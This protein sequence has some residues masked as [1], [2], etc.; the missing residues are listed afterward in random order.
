[1]F[2]RLFYQIYYRRH[3]RTPFLFLVFLLAIVFL[4]QQR[5]FSSTSTSTIVDS[6]EISIVKKKE[7][8]SRET[9]VVPENCYRCPGENGIGVSLTVSCSTFAKTLRKK[10]P[11]FMSLG[12]R[13]ARFGS[14]SEKRLF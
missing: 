11:F 14:N 2:H 4:F 13:S 8:I 7:R 3:R 9:Y 1:M 6:T 5:P 10:K 12:R